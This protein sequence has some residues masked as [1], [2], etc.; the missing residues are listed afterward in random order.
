MI[1]PPPE[2]VPPPQTTP[3]SKGSSSHHSNQTQH[4]RA[5]Y[6]TYLEQDINGQLIVTFHEFIAFL[7]SENREPPLPALEKITQMEEFLR[8]L[9]NF[10]KVYVHETEMYHPFALLANYILSVLPSSSSE[11][12]LF[13][14]N[15]P[16]HVKGC[17]A[18]RSPDVICA[19]QR[20]ITC[21][22]RSCPDTQ[23]K[24]GPQ[25][26]PYHWSELL[27]FV[28]FKRTSP[29]RKQ[30]RMFSPSHIGKCL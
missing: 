25:G 8:L 12:I 18:E 10:D 15:D 24:A 26:A 22:A 2:P 3:Y 4:T 14:R 19:R 7:S 16:T 30:S 9:N 1:T 11:S 27:A 6:A 23:S 5:Q 20:T 28:E 17:K 13:T 29:P 21:G